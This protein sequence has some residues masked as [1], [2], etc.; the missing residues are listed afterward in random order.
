MKAQA[1]KSQINKQQ[2]IAWKTFNTSK[3]TVEWKATSGMAE[4]IC[5]P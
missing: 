5:K 2:Y 3:E 4:N 1:A